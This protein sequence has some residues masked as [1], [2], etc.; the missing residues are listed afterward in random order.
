ML[1]I[2][3]IVRPHDDTVSVVFDKYKNR[4]DSLIIKHK[5]IGVQVIHNTQIIEEPVPM[6]RYFIWCGSGVVAGILLTL[7]IGK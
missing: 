7:L 2:D 1:R 3:T 5:P 4:L 6:S